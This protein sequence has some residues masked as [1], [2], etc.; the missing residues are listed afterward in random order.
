MT[1]QTSAAERG[2]A[3]KGTGIYGRLAAGVTRVLVGNQDGTAYWTTVGVHDNVVAASW[4]ALQDAI[5]FGLLRRGTEPS[6]E[7]AEAN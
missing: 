3:A 5:N 2:D 7:P 6:G 4:M 1:G